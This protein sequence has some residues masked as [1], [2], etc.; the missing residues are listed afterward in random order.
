VTTQVL[1][2]QYIRLLHPND[3]LFPA[4]IFYV[5]CVVA[6]KPGSVIGVTLATTLLVLLKEALRF[7]PLS[8]SV[9]GPLRLILFGM[10]LFGVVYWRRDSLFPEQRRV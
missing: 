5:T 9:L 6:G 10:I 3:Y 8:A 4:L 1:F 2:P 7:V